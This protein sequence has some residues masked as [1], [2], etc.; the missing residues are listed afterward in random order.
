MECGDMGRYAN[1]KN[2]LSRRA[3]FLL[4]E[5]KAAKIVGD[6]KRQ[7]A[8]TWYDTVPAAFQKA[9]LKLFAEPSSIWDFLYEAPIGPAKDGL[10]TLRVASF[11]RTCSLAN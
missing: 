4:D 1:A 10:E 7:V 5:N 3:R 9:T 6:M 8:A 2:I 11:R